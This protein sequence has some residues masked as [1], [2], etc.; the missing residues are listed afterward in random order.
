MQPIEIRVDEVPAE[1]KEEP[2]HSTMSMGDGN[3]EKAAKMVSYSAYV[4][5]Q[6]L[7]SSCFAKSR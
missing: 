1:P 3:V 2:P 6:I 5:N 4:Q 7:G